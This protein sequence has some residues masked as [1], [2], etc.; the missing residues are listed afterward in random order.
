MMK[1]GKVSAQHIEVVDGGLPEHQE[2]DGVKVMGTVK[3]TES[4][5]VY[6]PTPTADPQVLTVGISLVSGFGGLLSFYI[7]ECAAAGKGYAAISQLMTYPTHFMGIGNLIGMPLAI[8]IGRR[9]VLLALLCFL[10][11]D[12]SYVLPRNHMSGDSGCILLLLR[13]S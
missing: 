8:A 5:I 6:I 2:P 10:F 1:P 9:I 4:S 12:L 7:P 13:W 3:L 11:S